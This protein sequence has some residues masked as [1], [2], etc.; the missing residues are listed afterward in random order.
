MSARSSDMREPTYL[1]RLFD[2][3]GRLLYVGITVNVD[4]RMYSHAMSKSWWK[5]VE[6]GDMALYPTRYAAGDAETAAINVQKPRYNRD[7]WTKDG[8]YR[9]SMDTFPFVTA[10]PFDPRPM[11]GVW[12]TRPDPAVEHNRAAAPIAVPKFDPALLAHMSLADLFEQFI[13]GNGTPLAHTG[14]DD[15]HTERPSHLSDTPTSCHAC[16]QKVPLDILGFCPDC[17]DIAP[18][19]S[20]RVAAPSTHGGNEAALRPAASSTHHLTN[21]GRQGLAHPDGPTTTGRNP[22]AAIPD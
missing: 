11:G 18:P 8:P 20:R 4:F 19:F 6:T 21:E 2:A 7:G 12:S 10:E 16:G 15:H 17:G 14:S 5:D 1:Y 22:D 3:T 9:S 13:V